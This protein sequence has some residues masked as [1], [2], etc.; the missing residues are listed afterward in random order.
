MKLT[1]TTFTVTRIVGEDLDN[2]GVMKRRYAH[3]LQGD[4]SLGSINEPENQNVTHIK[5]EIKRYI[6]NI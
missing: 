1:P 2:L 6:W 5:W 3:D 4:L